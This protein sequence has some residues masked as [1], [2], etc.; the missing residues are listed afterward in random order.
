[1]NRT[2]F[3]A[4]RW[5]GRRR[6]TVCWLLAAL[7]TLAVAGGALTGTAA[8]EYPRTPAALDASSAPSDGSVEAPARIAT[9]SGVVVAVREAGF[10]LRTG[11]RQVVFVRTDGNTKYR[12]K[13][14]AVQR[15]DLRP[16][17]QVTVLG[18]VQPN[19]R[20]R[21]RAVSL[22]GE[23]IAVQATTTVRPGNPAMQ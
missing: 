7:A 17:Q 14:A 11:A 2:L 23:A 19:G 1:M 10:A 13:G 21:A 16:Q 18:R 22:R 5:C 15:A 6:A 12:R 9:V 8:A 3:R 4:L 20:L